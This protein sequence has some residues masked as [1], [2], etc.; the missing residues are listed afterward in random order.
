MKYR[1]NPMYPHLN[2]KENFCGPACLQMILFRKGKWI[3]QELLAQKIGAGIHKKDK[4]LYI[5]PFPSFSGKTYRIGVDIGEFAKEKI[6]TF[7]Q[8]FKLKS[9][10][11]RISKI[12]EVKAFIIENLKKGNDIMMNFW[13]KPFDGRSYGHFVLV[14]DFD[15]ET[16]EV[17]VCD[18]SPY[19]KSFWKAS[20]DKFIKAMHPKWDKKERGFVVFKRI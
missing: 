15:S 12:K 20:I 19:K 16:G 18:P 9:E 3:S 14:A 11:Y 13:W 5:L 4:D 1:V 2:Q 17:T 8:K 6:N 7:L 10:I